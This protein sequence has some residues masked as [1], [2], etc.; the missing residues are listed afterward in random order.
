MSFISQN[1][2]WFI[3]EFVHNAQYPEIRR[4][5]LT[6]KTVNQYCQRPDI[7][8]LIDNKLDQ[9]VEKLLVEAESNRGY[10]EKFGL[11]TKLISNVPHHEFFVTYDFTFTEKF[12]YIT[13]KFTKFIIDEF[14]SN[15]SSEKKI[16]SGTRTEIWSILKKLVSRGLIG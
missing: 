3:P 1:A 8:A 5:C 6:D 2:T 7:L 16:I 13:E 10:P 11:P 4:L 15:P 9:Y 14:D 12:Y